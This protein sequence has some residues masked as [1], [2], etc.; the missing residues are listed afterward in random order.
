MRSVQERQ[1]AFFF[2][3]GPKLVKVKK[4]FDM[5]SWSFLYRPQVHSVRTINA[6]GR[7]SPSTPLALG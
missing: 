5:Q 6:S 2:Q 4:K 1:W 7:Y 3:D